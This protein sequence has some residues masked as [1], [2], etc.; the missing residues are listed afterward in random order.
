MPARVWIFGEGNNELGGDDGYGAR[1]GGVLASLLERVCEHGWT[2]AGA[3]PWRLIQKF[4]AGGAHRDRSSH[5]DY[6]NVLGLV[7]TAYEN[8]ADAVAFA[9]DV[10]GDLDR[11]DAIQAALAWLRDDSSWAIHVIGGVAKPAI[12]GWILA[13]RA[14]P[15]TDDMSRARAAALL[16]EHEIDPKST[17][18]YRAAVAQASLGKSP[19][20]GLP[21]GAESLR[22]WLAVAAEVMRQLVDSTPPP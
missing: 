15:D 20:F 18:H 11:E 12:E 14:V 22:A 8:A 16:A 9:R 13:L 7:F 3:M 19:H 6:L 17:E 5:G 4:R 10:D 2:C 21:R 1:Q